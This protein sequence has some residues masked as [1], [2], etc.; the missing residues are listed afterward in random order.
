MW[1][2]GDFVLLALDVAYLGFNRF[3]FAAFVGFFRSAFLLAVITAVLCF[4]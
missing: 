4:S 2:C 3:V 1:H